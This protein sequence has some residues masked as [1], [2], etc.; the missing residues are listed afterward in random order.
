MIAGVVTSLIASGFVGT[1]HIGIVVVG[2]I[3]G[4]IAIIGVADLF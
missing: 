2:T 3:A 1:I 4:M